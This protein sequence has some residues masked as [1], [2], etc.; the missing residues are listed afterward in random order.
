VVGDTPSSLS[1]EPIDLTVSLIA[2]ETA[3]PLANTI[4]ALT[5]QGFASINDTGV[6]VIS[7][8]IENQVT[9]LFAFANIGTSFAIAYETDRS[10]LCW[11]PATGSDTAPSVVHRYNVFTR[12]WTKYEKAALAAIVNPADDKIYYCDDDSN[13]VFKERK[14][15]DYT[16]YTD[17]DVAVTITAISGATV[18]LNA[19]YPTIE[20]GD[21]LT[22]GSNPFVTILDV[23]LNGS[24]NTVL[25]IAYEGEFTVAAAVVKRSYECTTAFAPQFCGDPGM[26]KHVRECQALFKRSDFGLGKLRFSTDL[27][28]DT[29]DVVSEG[30][31]IEFWGYPPW[32]EFPWGGPEA[33]P[34]K[35]RVLIPA[36]HQIN[37][38][39]NT[40]FI[41]K[42]AFGYFEFAGMEYTFEPMSERT[43]K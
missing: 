1:I 17:E 22:Q 5:T 40:T 30:D 4:Y 14:D 24:G 6:G 28:S 7:R 8:S 32:G 16:D 34:S 3:R 21:A 20:E 11:V 43:Q 35:E 41:L 37:S 13:N 29:E 36:K 27:I 38:W 42:E 15:R 10:Y 39:I 33:E 19:A 18:T 9:K 12:Q 31:E 25:E 23:S 2:P 26:M